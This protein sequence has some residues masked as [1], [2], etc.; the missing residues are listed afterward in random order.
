MF[1]ELTQEHSKASPALLG[2]VASPQHVSIPDIPEQPSGNQVT[3]TRND[4]Q[5]ENVPFS[6][7]QIYVF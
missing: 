3:A 1:L 7:N 2:N 6:K 5:G 4:S